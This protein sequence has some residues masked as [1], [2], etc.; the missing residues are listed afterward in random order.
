[1]AVIKAS[2][3]GAYI[4]AQ[5]IKSDYTTINSHRVVL[6]YGVVE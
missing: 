2:G 1:M 4:S 6:G 3:T 5:A